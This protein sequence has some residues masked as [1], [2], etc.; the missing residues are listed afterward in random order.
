MTATNYNTISLSP[1]DS[2][3]IRNAIREISNALTRTEAER[4]LIKAILVQIEE[5]TGLP[6]KTLRK[7]ARIWHKQNLIEQEE[8]FSEVRDLYQIIMESG[9]TTERESE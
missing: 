9:N 2:Q 8:E 6:K 7:V 3:K 1:G 5:E 4:D